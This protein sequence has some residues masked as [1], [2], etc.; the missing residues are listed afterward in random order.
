MHPIRANLKVVFDTILLPRDPP[1]RR[2]TTNVER[3]FLA[4]RRLWRPDVPR[5]V[6]SAGKVQML[7]PHCVGSQSCHILRQTTLDNGGSRGGWRYVASHERK[8]PSRCT[9]P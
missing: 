4:R 8:A 3:E 7:V 1:V 5:T 6:D 2:N 9:V